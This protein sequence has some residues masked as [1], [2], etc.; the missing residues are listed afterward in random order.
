MRTVLASNTMKE[1]P[2]WSH[3]GEYIRTRTKRRGN[4]AETD[5]EPEWATEAFSDECAV[6]FDPDPASNSGSSVRTIG[7]SDRAGFLISVITVRDPKTGHLWGANAFKSNDTDQ[8]KY[9]QG[10][11][12][13]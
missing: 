1:L 10:A 13:G 8:R 3:R 9:E 11:E 5:I 12:N 4:E 7:W 2:D 6:V